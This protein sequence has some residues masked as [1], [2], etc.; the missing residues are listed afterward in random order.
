MFCHFIWRLFPRKSL[1][2]SLL[3]VYQFS[4]QNQEFPF[5][6]IF[7]AFSLQLWQLSRCYIT[8]RTSSFMWFLL[9]WYGF[10]LENEKVMVHNNIYSHIESYKHLNRN[11]RV[12]TRDPPTSL[13]N[14]IRD[15]LEDSWHDLLRGHLPTGSFVAICCSEAYNPGGLCRPTLS[16]KNALF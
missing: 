10:N 4:H 16:P 14:I 5:L 8:I 1:A 11:H 7:W 13:I 15:C 3:I 2:N 12:I 6:R 9:R